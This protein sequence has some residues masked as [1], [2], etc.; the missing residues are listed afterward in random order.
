MRA[1]IESEGAMRR[2]GIGLCAVALAL[3]LPAARAGAAEAAAE[4]RTRALEAAWQFSVDD[5]K[6]F[7]AA[8]P[9]AATTAVGCRLTSTPTWG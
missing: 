5:G 6:T 9:E 1:N 8:R 7:A 3:S 2:Y 4:P